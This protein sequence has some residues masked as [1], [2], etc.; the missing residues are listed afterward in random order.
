MKLVSFDMSMFACFLIDCLWIIDVCWKTFVLIWLLLKLEKNVLDLV[1]AWWTRWRLRNFV[2]RFSVWSVARF[3][4]CTA[5]VHEKKLMHWSSTLPR[6]RN[7][8]PGRFDSVDRP[9]WISDTGRF[10]P[11]AVHSIE[12]LINHFISFTYFNFYFI[13]FTIF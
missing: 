3:R 11:S 9:R 13:F 12:M 5:C 4:S 2:S 7:D 1:L 10:A 6:E 8:W